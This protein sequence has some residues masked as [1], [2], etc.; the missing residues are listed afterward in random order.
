MYTTGLLNFALFSSTLCGKFFVLV[1]LSVWTLFLTLC[2]AGLPLLLIGLLPVLHWIFLF[3]LMGYTFHVIIFAIFL[4]LMI[5]LRFF[6]KRELRLIEEFGPSQALWVDR[7]F[8]LFSVLPVRHIVTTLELGNVVDEQNLLLKFSEY[9]GVA[10]SDLDLYHVA[11]IAWSKFIVTVDH[12]VNSSPYAW[13]LALIFVMVRFLDYVK[14]SLSFFWHIGR[15]YALSVW[16]IVVSTPSQ[17]WLLAHFLIQFLNLFGN[18]FSPTFW[19]YIKWTLTLWSVHLANYLVEA[20]FVSRKWAWKEGFSTVRPQASVVSSLSSF[21]ARLSIVI[22]DMGLPSY[23]RGGPGTFDKGTIEDT[24]DMMKSLGWPINVEL[25]EPSDFGKNAGYAEWL[26]TGTTWAQGIHRRQMQVDELLDPLRVKAIEFRNTVTYASKE[27]EIRSLARYFKSPRYDFPTLELDDV[28]FLV[29]DI[30]RHS[31]LTPFNYIIKMWEKKYALGSF[32]VDPKRPWKK[33]SRK[34]FIASIGYAKFKDLWRRTFE[35][36]PLLTPVSHVSIKGEALPPR[37][38][39]EDKVRTVIGSPLGQYI[40][41]TIWNFQPN[42]NFKWRETPIKVGMPLNGFWMSRTF[43][44]HNRCQEH[45]AGDMSDFDSTLT[46]ETKRLIKEVRKRGFE[47]H[48]DRDRI[49]LLIDINYHQVERQ[50]LHTT[51]TGDIYDDGTG[52]TTGHSSTSMDNSIATVV[53]YL[54]A[55]KRLTGLSAREF[56]FYNELSCF[57][58]D[59]VLSYLS[60]KPAAWSFGNI[61]HVMKTFGIDM[62]LEASGKLSNIPF[63]SKTVRVPNLR[64]MADFVSA[65]LGSYRPAFAV[66]HDRERLLGKLTAPIKT[67]D[68]VYRYKRMLSYLSLTAHHPDIYKQLH[69]ILTTMTSMKRAQRTTGLPVPSYQKVISDWYKPDA[70][71]VL[72]D[73]DQDFEDLKGENLLVSYGNVSLFD[74]LVGGLALIPDLVNP[75]IFNFGHVRAFQAQT[76]RLSSW[77][78]DLL[79]IQNEAF[80]PADLRLLLRK[81]CYDF[82]DPS[83]Y[84]QMASATNVTSLLVRHWLF[85]WYVQRFRSARSYG[86]LSGVLN[87][88]SSFAFLLNAKVHLETRAGWTVFIDILVVALLGFIKVPPVLEFMSA[89]WVPNVS[90]W[91]DRL[92]YSIYARFWTS[93]PPNYNDV[94]VFLDELASKGTQFVLSA[95]TGTGKTTAFI[96]HLLLR[97]GSKYDK[98]IVIEP[99]SAI[100]KTVVP[101]VTSIMGL[102]ASGCTT[103]VTLE[104]SAKIWYV[105]AQEWLLHPSW[106]SLNALIVMDE[107]HVNEPAYMLV[108]EELLAQKLKVIYASATPP[109]HLATLPTIV[110]NTAKIWKV[111]RVTYNRPEIVGVYECL[112]DYNKQ[113]VDLITVTPRVSTILVFVSTVGEALDLTTKI[114][115]KCVILSAHSGVDHLEEAEVI[116]ATSV[117]DVGITLP[118]VDTVISSDI[119]FTVSNTLAETKKRHFK[120]SASALTQ[121]AGRTGRTNNGTFHLYSYPSSGLDFSTETLSST[122]ACTE[123][124]TSGIPM[125]YLEKYCKGALME[126]IGVADRDEKYQKGVFTDTVKQLDEYRGQLQPILLERAAMMDLITNTG[127]APASIGNFLSLLDKSRNKDIITL[128]REELPYILMYGKQYHVRGQEKLDLESAINSLALRKSKG[129]LDNIFKQASRMPT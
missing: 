10:E 36:A 126:L 32:M 3:P 121:R 4:A 37:K 96:Q 108:T 70:K 120:L 110:L 9:M 127:E 74:S 11:S 16:V 58:D 104:P 35:V 86:F 97:E 106:H 54:M 113:V 48:K 53:L 98:I 125:L 93:L 124:L 83:I 65:K 84:V 88:L 81:T 22:S 92:W 17:F 79:S 41:S 33:Y 50:L 38:W 7:D 78:M 80:G 5:T 77:P 6:L 67:M 114:P 25:Q 23:I 99:R 82:L 2:V 56:K 75:A 64:D 91:L 116:L 29:G 103:G 85:C 49:A 34:D 59:H 39:M 27:N 18:I 76:S 73:I 30:F 14:M 31:R 90:M 109:A 57:G 107:C 95:P 118:H 112:K 28:W 13:Q 129:F 61:Q 94:G 128:I 52:L 66:V 123:L 55:W 45:F 71:F 101:Y 87:K 115:R 68:P 43:E 51:S 60:T 62:R 19:A 40:M 1:L 20:E 119:G 12:V 46:G 42:H 26:V 15:F 47:S 63:L 89:L 111:H 117:A 105:T 102:P 24:L 72:N 21:M 44:A 69:K 100:I 8:S 122:T